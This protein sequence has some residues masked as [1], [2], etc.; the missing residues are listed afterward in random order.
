MMVQCLANYPE[1]REES[2]CLNE[3][4]PPGC[5]SSTWA[6][7]MVVHDHLPG[8]CDNNFHNYPCE[9][10]TVLR[11][12][13]LRAVHA[14]NK[15]CHGCA[16]TIANFT[17]NFVQRHGYVCT[18][19]HRSRPVPRAAR[20]LELAQ[21]RLRNMRAFTLEP[22][23][24]A[25]IAPVHL[26]ALDGALGRVSLLS[27]DRKALEILKEA[28]AAPLH[29]ERPLEVADLSQGERAALDA[30]LSEELLLYNQAAQQEQ[31][32]LGEIRKKHV[33]DFL[34]LHPF[35]ESF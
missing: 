29:A 11:H 13:L 21:A 23:L 4:L 1:E 28:S 10:V 2:W 14:Y 16:H 19:G 31:E 8:F 5:C 18:L 27:R 15:Y 24:N 3:R 12:P 34:R 30:I 20:T 32:A 26:E 35:D 6:S 7:S 25:D 33:R 22:F 17:S 9:Y